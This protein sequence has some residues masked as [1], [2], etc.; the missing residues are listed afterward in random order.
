MARLL[1]CV[2]LAVAACCLAQA[3]LPAFIVPG[4]LAR[5]DVIAASGASA[6]LMASQAAWADAQ[7]EPTAILWRYGS[8]IANLE[9]AI[10]KG[11]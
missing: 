8:Y 3:F 2:M 1:P 4:Q 11:D 10:E 6:A 9:G 5:R 7:G